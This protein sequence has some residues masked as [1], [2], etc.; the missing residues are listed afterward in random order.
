MVE[1]STS[2]SNLLLELIGSHTSW[3]GYL[4]DSLRGRVIDLIALAVNKLPLNK[5]IDASEISITGEHCLSCRSRFSCG[6]YV[7]ALKE[8][9]CGDENSICSPYD[10]TGVVKKAS[11]RGDLIDLIVSPTGG[12]T[13][14]IMGLPRSIYPEFKVG[15]SIAGYF[16]GTLDIENRCNFPA[17]FYVIRDE[18]PRMSS[19][20]SMVALIN[21][22]T[23]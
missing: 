3:S 12:V 1:N 20:E 4:D 14:A 9:A 18:A 8:R 21:D 5:E 2:Y 15:D 13:C 11:A 22:G 7:N 17:N 23:R 19:F 6:K 10:V 16:L